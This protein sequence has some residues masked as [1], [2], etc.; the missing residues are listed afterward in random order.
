M[1]ADGVA[2]NRVVADEVA[3]YSV[4]AAH[5][6][7]AVATCGTSRGSG[8]SSDMVLKVDAIRAEG[9]MV[10]M[11]GGHQVLDKFCSKV[12]AEASGRPHRGRRYEHRSG[13]QA[14]RVTQVGHARERADAAASGLRPRPTPPRDPTLSSH[15]V[16]A[17]GSIRC[18]I[19][20]KRRAAQGT[21]VL[22]THE[23]QSNYSRSRPEQEPD[24]R[25]K[26]QLEIVHLICGH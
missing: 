4:A 15:G 6:R 9:S 11:T 26:A 10:S 1:A 23:Y 16:P 3:A 19:K 7:L 5:E 12:L 14:K 13:Q 8:T 17:S 2:A 25:C 18:S 20:S 22:S 24:W 21:T